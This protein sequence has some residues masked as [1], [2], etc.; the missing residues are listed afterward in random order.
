MRWKILSI[1]SLLI[2][3]PALLNFFSRKAQGQVCSSCSNTNCCGSSCTSNQFCKGTT[4]YGCSCAACNIQC[5]LNDYNK[6]YN[7]CSS[8]PSCTTG[9]CFPVC[10]YCTGQWACTSS[11]NNC[12][13][14]D[15]TSWS[16]WSCSSD[17]V[18]ETRYC[19]DPPKCRNVAQARQPCSGNV[20]PS[21]P[22]TSSPPSPTPTSTPT[23][24]P[25]PTL[26][27]TVAIYGNLKE[28][29]GAVCNNNISSN[30]VSINLIPQA[31]AGVTSSCGI[32]PPSGQVKSSYR[33][34]VT[35][36]NQ[37]A[38]PNPNQNLSLQASALN[39]SSAYWTNNNLCSSTPNNAVL[40]NVATQPPINV[41]NKDIFFNINSPWIK[42]KNTSFLTSN[43]LTNI[44]PQNITPYD[45][46]DTNERYFIIGN[47]PGNVIAT[48]IN[49]GTAQ[50][51]SKNWTTE[52]YSQNLIFYSVDSFFEYVKSKKPYQ[53]INNLDNLTGEK[54]NLWQGNLI[55]NSLNQSKFDGKKIVLLVR[56]DL[57][58]DVQNFSP[59]NGILAAIAQNINFSS[60][61]QS[62]T[63]IFISQTIN[64]G[65]TTNQGLKIIGNLIT[66][67]LQNERKWDDNSRPS[68][69]LV[70]KPEFY[71][72]L[73]P[74]LSVRKYEWRQLQ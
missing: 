18:T 21:T 65:L 15:C 16:N 14:S 33:C 40:V 50:P 26:Y 58:I 1:L 55:I 3:L 43:S 49:L 46:E 42:L 51:S 19:L 72:D 10:N 44:I 39:Y 9:Q 54:I 36:N 53:Q 60:N 13:F 29:L 66:K 35:F 41:F 68:L 70:F 38:N 22:E 24:T 37:T 25:T 27:P 32:T 73:L 8:L 63:G 7:D 64:T 71:L 56:G 23:P 30:L 20:V 52:N 67:T 4:T 62:A 6:A 2:L 57:T 5:N 47:A 11:T 12:S 34:T 69:F 28:Y 31:P 74:Y 45:S 17:G 59:I 61:V 48:S